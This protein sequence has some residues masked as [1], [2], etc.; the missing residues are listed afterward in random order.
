MKMKLEM[1]LH[2]L[3]ISAV[4]LIGGIVNVVAQNGDC[5][6]T[7]TDDNIGQEVCLKK[8]TRLCLRLNAQ[9]ATGFGWKVTKIDAAKLKLVSESTEKTS[10]DEVSREIQIFNFK[11]ISKGEFDLELSYFRPWEKEKPP[12]KKY[13]LKVKIN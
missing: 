7:L 4:L 10:D 2:L 11:A 6:T 13:I 3:A 8:G 9:L 1:F 5:A 12:A